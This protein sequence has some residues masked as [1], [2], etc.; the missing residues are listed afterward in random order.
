MTT[1]GFDKL[2][3]QKLEYL[4]GLSMQDILSEELNMIEESDAA[5]YF[6]E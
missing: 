2:M 4:F 1:N 6:I 3:V 5:N